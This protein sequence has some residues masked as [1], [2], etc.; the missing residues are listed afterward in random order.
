MADANVSQLEINGTTY[1]I[2]DAT[3]R[4]SLSQNYLPLTAGSDK[5]LTGYLNIKSDD[6]DRDGENPSSTQWGKSIVFKDKDFENLG[7]VNIIRETDGRTR[8]SL[9]AYN[10]DGNGD[11]QTNVLSLYTAK[12]GTHSYYI[13]SP[14][15]FRSAISAVDKSGDVFSGS[16]GLTPNSSASA[17]YLYLNNTNLN[18]DETAPSSTTVGNSR[19]I[20]RD[21]D[22]EQIGRV[23]VVTDTNG[24]NSIQLYAH[25]EKSG[26]EVSN[27]F[28]IS[29]KRDGTQ[30]YNVSSP[31]NF[32]SA[33][34]TTITRTY[35]ISSNL[36]VAQNTPTKFLEVTLLQGLNLLCW[37]WYVSGSTTAQN[38]NWLWSTS[39]TA[40]ITPALGTGIQVP[41]GYMNAGQYHTEITTF[42]SAGTQKVYL[43]GS[44]A[45]T[46]NL[47][48]RAAAYN[49]IIPFGT[50]A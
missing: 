47:S 34:G 43:Y 46:G 2:C 49:F 41:V 39:T 42:W 29:V 36:S 15:A 26:T 37:S 25:N 11:E 14:T 22:N 17:A 45:G 24:I 35:E 12:D 8:L 27:A 21:A 23:T 16:V 1:D 44:H 48:M 18:R 40:T 3:A 33:I 50:Q 19:I 31:A 38:V 6:I 13:S 20:F 32:R 7:S 10:E 28:T 4:D 5:P 9:Y 30:T